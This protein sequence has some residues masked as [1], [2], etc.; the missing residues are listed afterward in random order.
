MRNHQYTGSYDE[1][2][3]T[4]AIADAV[5]ACRNNIDS[6]ATMAATLDRHAN[7]LRAE[8]DA[9]VEPH[10]RLEHRDHDHLPFAVIDEVGEEFLFAEW[11]EAVE[12]AEQHL[13]GEHD[14]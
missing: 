8:A 7:R 1:Q 6:D 5:A 2:P 11:T 14:E 12:F 10:V 9:D 4:I 13:A 3:F